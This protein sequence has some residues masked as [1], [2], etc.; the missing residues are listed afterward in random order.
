[1]TTTILGIESSCDETAA[2]VVT[3]Q[4]E[5]L[6][7]VIS[8]QIPVHARYGG[9]IPELASRNHLMA[10]PAVVGEALAK[11]QVSLGDLTRIAATRGPGL[12]GA[13]MVGLQFAK[14]LAFQTG[15][16]LVAVHHVEGHITA[17][18]L[19]GAGEHPH[20]PLTF[21]YVAL[22]VS[23]GHTSLYLVRR[24][25]DYQL[26]GVTLDDAAGEAFDKVARVLGLPY[27]GGVEIDRLAQQG[28][29]AAF[30]FPRPL[31]GKKNLDFSFSGLKTAV[32]LTVD[33]LL[34]ADQELPRADIAA[35]FQQ[36][37]V[38]VLL[39]KTFAAAHHVGVK[40]VVIA[41]GVAANSRLRSELTHRAQAA[42]LRGH[43]TRP[44]YCTDNAAMIAGAGRYQTPLDRRLRQTIEPFASGQLT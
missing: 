8:S 20:G 1:M 27:P 16:E 19:D 18:L 39:R 17:I 36:A 42:G 4:G 12:V 40:D 31:K 41:G 30:D 11:A 24:P 9:V 15:A 23:G 10:M 14:G 34:A 33:K 5:I 32:K 22:A 38:D 13:L 2:A 7:N 6:S 26:L 35:A 25:G 28:D 43:L 44:V 37:V 3:G 29:P 21:P